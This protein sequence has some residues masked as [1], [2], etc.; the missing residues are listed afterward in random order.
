MTN[1]AIP[2]LSYEDV[3]GAVDWLTKAF[4]FREVGERY[5]DE[6]GWLSHAELELDGA[7]V[8]LGWP[9][10]GYMSPTHHAQEC[11]HAR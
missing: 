9:G 1:Q 5:T 2:M 6:S 11:D 7:L 8:Y 3:A 10:E 4:G